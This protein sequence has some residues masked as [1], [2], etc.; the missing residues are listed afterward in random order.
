MGKGYRQGRLGEEIKKLVSSMLL[1]DLKD[2]RLSGMIS[3]SD[4]EVTKDNSYATCYVT[5]L[6]ASRDEEAVRKEE[7]QVIE[8]LDS[9]KG[10]IRK[11]IGKQ[12][13]LRHAPELIFKIDRSMEYGRH[14]DE[15]IK[16]LGIDDEE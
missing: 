5:V 12:M 3:I 4:V 11:E 7:E 15:V 6:T 14:I 8:G 1:R 13:K 9:A 10:L 16:K 2:P